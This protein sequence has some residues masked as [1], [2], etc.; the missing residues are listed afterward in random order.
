ME[1]FDIL[2]NRRAWK[3]TLFMRIG[4]KTMVFHLFL[5]DL[6]IFHPNASPGHIG[7][8]IYPPSAYT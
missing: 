2:L 3:R 5:E 1:M 4:L 8:A 6:S 7:P